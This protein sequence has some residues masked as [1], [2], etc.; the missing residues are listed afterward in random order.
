MKSTKQ[1]FCYQN[2]KISIHKL[3]YKRASSTLI[4]T[5]ILLRKN[6]STVVGSSLELLKIPIS[7]LFLSS[8][9]R[10]WS[11]TKYKRLQY[12]VVWIDDFETK[13]RKNKVCPLHRDTFINC[14]NQNC[15]L[16]IQNCNI[17]AFFHNF[18][19][20]TFINFLNKT[21]CITTAK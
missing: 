7:K 13:T 10:N 16:S 3:Q 15:W 12:Q 8:I 14:F 1:A 9:F 6:V 17:S 18:S 19:L 2:Q 11:Y 21:P 4:W 5:L 20:Q